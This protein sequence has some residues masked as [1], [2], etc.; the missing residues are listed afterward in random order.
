MESRQL[1]VIVLLEYFQ[2]KNLAKEKLQ[3]VNLPVF[4]TIRNMLQFQ[5]TRRTYPWNGVT[6]ATRSI[7]CVPSIVV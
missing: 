1:Q 5:E 7:P 2:N 6:M 3:N 4:I